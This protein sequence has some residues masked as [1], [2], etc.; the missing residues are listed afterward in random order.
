MSVHAVASQL[1]HATPERVYAIYRDYRHWP[2]VFPA[3]IRATRLIRENET[4]QAIEVDHARAG[5]VLNLLTVLSS[6][7]IRLDEFKPHYDARFTNRI[8][9]DGRGT[10]FTVT[11]DVQLKGILRLFALIARPFV[12]RRIAKFVLRPIKV[13]AEARSTDGAGAPSTKN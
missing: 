9:A 2:D 8:E 4:T 10:L 3:T 13:I 6:D 12:R 11:A 1:I 5:R 7:E